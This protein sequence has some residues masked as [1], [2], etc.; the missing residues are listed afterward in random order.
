[1]PMKEASQ[2]TTLKNLLIAR[3]KALLR[4]GGWAGEGG[5]ARARV[6]VDEAREGEK[7]REGDGKSI[8]WRKRPP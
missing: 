1:M 4:E 6:K 3:Q 2:I 7:E 5:C 8:V